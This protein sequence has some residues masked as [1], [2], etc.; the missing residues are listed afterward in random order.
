[1]PKSKI[2]PEIQ[3]RILQLHREGHKYNS[4]ASLVGLDWRTVKGV[5]ARVAKIQE[6]EHWQAVTRQVDSQI[7]QQ[8]Y[9]LLLAVAQELER[10]INRQPISRPP[11]QTAQTILD[12]TLSEAARR[13][14]GQALLPAGLLVTREDFANARVA[15][16]G[17]RVFKGLQEHEPQLGKFIERWAHSCDAFAS[18]RQKLAERLE[19]AQILEGKQTLVARLLKQGLTESQA[20]DIVSAILTEALEHQV[21]GM[22]LMEF[23]GEARG[24]DIIVITRVRKDPDQIHEVY[25]GKGAD[26]STVRTVYENA[27]SWVL[28]QPEVWDKLSNAYRDIAKWTEEVNK[29]LDTLVLR[30]R[31]AGRCNLCPSA[32]QVGTV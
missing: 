31:P 28:Q 6:Q 26:A 16:Y 15:R 13:A 32:E 19:H 17:Q 29:C 5:V 18:E 11:H 10:E 3:N 4:I 23:Q 30:G 22:Q 7:L 20:A 27:L 8:H 14:A 1:M 25:S 9:K 2:T 12:L 24:T 21:Q